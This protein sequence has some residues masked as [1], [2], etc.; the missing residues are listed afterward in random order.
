MGVEDRTLAQ[1][2]KRY[3]AEGYQ[4][5]L[6]PDE[7]AMPA[8][9]SRF[10]ADMI[11]TRGSEKV[12][13]EVK[14]NQRAVQADRQLTAL[15]E[16][17][18]GQPEWRLDVV[19]VGSQ[20]SLDKVLD[21]ASEPSAEQVEE[22]LAKSERIARDGHAQS[23]Y[24]AAWA[25]LEAA[26]RHATDDADWYGPIAPKELMNALYANG[27]LSRDEFDTLKQAYAVRTQIVHGLIPTRVDG[28]ALDQVIGI[29]RKLLTAEESAA[30]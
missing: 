11:A 14:Q 1:I 13:I 17:I 15:A 7:N 16:V 21:E 26:M 12:V 30:S 23:A 28:F 20:S 25:A 24:L 27:I 10:K 18:N 8:F 5:I 6:R 22:M 3:E 29:A 4:V 2:A 19:V 9:A